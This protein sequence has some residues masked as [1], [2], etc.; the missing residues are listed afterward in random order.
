VAQEQDKA[1]PM[2]PLRVAIVGSGVGGCATAH[3]LRKDL[4]PEVEISV[5][6]QNDRVGGRVDTVEVDGHEYEAGGS[7]IHSRN[8]YMKEFTKEVGLESQSTPDSE[9]GLFDG[10]DFV[11]E[12]SPWLPITLGRLLWRYGLDNIRLS[13]WVNHLLEYFS[14]IY[15]LQDQGKAFETPRELVAAMN[16]EFVR[17]LD[18]PLEKVLLERGFSQRFIDEFVMAIVRVNY[19]QSP[20]VPAFV[21]SVA[22]AGTGGDLWSVKGGNRLVPEK[23][24]AQSKPSR[25]LFGYRV[26][27]IE[28]TAEGEYWMEVANLFGREPSKTFKEGPFD[29]IFLACPMM[30]N[31]RTTNIKFVNLE[32]PQYKPYHRTV[33]TF[34]PGKLQA[35][36]KTQ[37]TPGMVLTTSA[38]L[39][40]NSVGEYGTSKKETVS[41]PVHKVFSKEIL[42]HDKLGELFQELNQTETKVRDWLAYP[43]YEE[44]TWSGTNPFSLDPK[45]HLYLVNCIEEVASCMEM[46]CIGA[47]NCVLLAKSRLTIPQA[48]L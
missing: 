9:L 23:L 16:P 2:A 11:F 39:Y 1:I 21:G 41:E 35:L 15:S 14:R 38:N 27:T 30:S 22:L 8:E 43:A 37:P 18:I 29:M 5:F 25:T 44:A 46:S 31:A 40:F 26:H 10:K 12:T 6:E 34:V 42:E 28:R 24:L 19:G 36:S 45:G 33:A 3:F 17:L 32:T 7:I 47:K 20:L 13:K 48:K 4:G